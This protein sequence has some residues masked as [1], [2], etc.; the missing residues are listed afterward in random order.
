MTYTDLITTETGL[1][2]LYGEPKGLPAAAKSDRLDDLCRHFISLSSFICISSCDV[3]GHQ[4]VS[5]R[6]DHPGFV[7]VIDERTLAIPDRPG[8]NK[9]ETLSNILVN[10]QVALLF[11]IPGHDETLRLFG[12]ARIS[13]S[14]DLRVLAA[15]DGKL[16]K[17][18]I[19]I[20]VE[21]IYPHC[22]KS[23]R[24]AQMWDSTN[25]SDRKEVPTLAAM[26]TK[27]A[28]IGYPKAEDV[29]AHL[30]QSYITGLY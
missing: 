17:S 29:D 5:P 20:T 10:P 27:M 1:R 4:D 12:R 14:S 19:L 26:A 16:P 21:Q 28:G 18:V 7:R 25:Y 8:N 22:G 2:A 13:C 9:L 23:L 15:V 3:E 11:M 30:Q 6:G 24:R